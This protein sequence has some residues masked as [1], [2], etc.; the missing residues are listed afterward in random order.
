MVGEMDGYRPET[1]GDHV[2]AVYDIWYPSVDANLVERLV[3]LAGP[4]PV[5][6]L[7]IGTG[8]VAPAPGRGESRGARRGRLAGHDRP[9]ARKTRR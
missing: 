9:A 7:A 5:L 4:G 6:E 3:E 2:A 1:Y 8:R